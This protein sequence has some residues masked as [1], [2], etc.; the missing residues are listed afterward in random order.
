MTGNYEVSIPEVGPAQGGEICI[1]KLDDDC[2]GVT[3]GSKCSLDKVE[4]GIITTKLKDPEFLAAIRKVLGKGPMADI[5]IEDAGKITKL[6]LIMKGI[7][8]I[9]GIEYFQNL[10]DL[11]IDNNNIKDIYPLSILTKLKTLSIEH[12]QIEDLSPLSAIEG[13]TE[14]YFSYNKISDISVVKNLINLT[15][16]RG[17]VNT[18]SDMSTV[19]EFTNLVE[20]AL[21]SNAI[22]DISALAKLVK[23]MHVSLQLNQIKDIA[24]GLLGNMGVG[25]GDYINLKGNP[26]IP[27]SQVN[28]LKQT[29]ANVYW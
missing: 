29:G 14:L 12:N 4:N 13:L 2:D 25:S 23:L 28:S 21:D 8:D 17:N 10:T 24:I 7:T 20:I 27:V 19:A 26:N 5:T 9:S 6:D 3:D 16:F 15:V 11:I 1:N 18:I 22:V